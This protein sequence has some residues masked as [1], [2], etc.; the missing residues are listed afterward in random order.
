MM[1][2]LRQE[3]EV[4]RDASAPMPSQLL[5]LTPPTAQLG[6]CRSTPIR[7]LLTPAHR[8]RSATILDREEAAA[9]PPHA[10]TL[11]RGHRG[12]ARQRIRTADATPWRE[13][14]APPR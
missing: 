4:N 7:D 5:T 13:W 6:D 8:R 14:S 3:R 1:V 12:L 10:T 2:D 9:T 11:V